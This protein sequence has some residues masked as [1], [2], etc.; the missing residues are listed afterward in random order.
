MSAGLRLVDAARTD[1]GK[2]R[3]ENEDS[4][5]ADPERGLYAVADGMGGFENGQWASQTVVESLAKTSLTEDFD[6]DTLSVAGALHAAN[7]QILEEAEAN[8]A[9]MG[10]TAV[11][12]L[13]QDARFAVLWAGDCRAYLWREGVLHRLTRDHTQVQDMVDRGFLAPEDA[14]HHPMSHIVSRAV[15][16]EEALEVDAVADEAQAGDVFLLC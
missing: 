3:K 12:L 8:A 7:A 6:A 14:A 5:F 10:A 2:V 9:R 16:V 13:I 11:A 1:V 4:F 15:G